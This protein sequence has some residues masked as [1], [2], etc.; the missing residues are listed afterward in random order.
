MYLPLI[1]TWADFTYNIA[2]V[3]I[4]A[5]TESAITI[6]AASIPFIRLMAKDISTRG[7]SRGQA[8]DNKVSYK[9]ADRPSAQDRLGTK[10]EIKAH[11]R[12]FGTS[13]IKGDDQSERSI[14]GDANDNGRIMQT[15][16][17]TIAYSESGDDASNDDR[18][19]TISLE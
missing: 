10:T 7:D 18:H 12:V 13:H 16:E 15:H 17:V 5:I 14:L 2:D 3:L 9:L 11:N 19:R 1:G 4:W 6:M 8:Y